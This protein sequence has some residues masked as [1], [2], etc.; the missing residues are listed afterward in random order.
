MTAYLSLAAWAG[1]C[2]RSCE[3]SRKVCRLGLVPGAIPFRTHQGKESYIVPEDAP[4]PR[5]LRRQAPATPPAGY[6][7]LPDWAQACDRN[8]RT[9]RVHLRLGHLPG[10]IHVGRTRRYVAIPEGTPW[11]A[12]AVGRP[13]KAVA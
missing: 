5:Y 10:A 7:L 12:K 6:L 9:A 1:A 3:R 2:G 11:P 13:R 8:I 4:W